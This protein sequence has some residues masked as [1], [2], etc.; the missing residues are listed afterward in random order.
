M[1]YKENFPIGTKVR[2]GSLVDLTAFTREWQF[3]HPLEPQQLKYADTVC[4]VKTVGFYHGG[5]VL[6]TLREVPGTWH[7]ACLRG[8]IPNEEGNS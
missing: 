7:E 2:I 8:A 1:P 4:K 5:D 3:H 6:Y